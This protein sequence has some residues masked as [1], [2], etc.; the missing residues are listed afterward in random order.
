MT[1]NHHPDDDTLMLLAAGQLGASAS[2]VI[3]AHTETCARCRS[4]LR[5]Y[6]QL[7][8]ALLDDLDMTP[9]AGGFER[10]LER[11]EAEDHDQAVRAVF[12][13]PAAPNAL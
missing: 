5:G 11:I 3:A 8:G 6:E 4:R 9:M 10:V 7:G 13:P 2:A 1:P 12:A